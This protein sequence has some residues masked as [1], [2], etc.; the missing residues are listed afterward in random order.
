[1]PRGRTL[2]ASAFSL[3]AVVLAAVHI[4]DPNLRIDEITLVLLAAAVLPWLGAVFKSLGLPGGI[5]IEYHDLEKVERDAERAGL[6]GPLPQIEPTY[7][8]I[9]DRDPRLALAGFRIELELKLR[10]IARRHNIGGDRQSVGMMVRR[11]ADEGILSADQ[12]SVLQDLIGLANSAV[13]GADVTPE[14]AR[15]AVD[16]GGSV[17]AALDELG[18]TSPR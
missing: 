8:A 13:H 4:A 17:L 12:R 15:W 6:V 18:G 14:A 16:V 5:T 11:L 7:V 2:V 3:G 1:M 10:E 9:A